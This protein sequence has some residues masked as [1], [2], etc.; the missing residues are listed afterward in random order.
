[1]TNDEKKTKLWKEF[2]RGVKLAMIGRDTYSR[3]YTWEE[4]EDKC[5]DI[6]LRNLS[7]EGDKLIN[8]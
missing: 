4:F 7:A 6:F 3:G 2:E 5:T 1:M 8:S